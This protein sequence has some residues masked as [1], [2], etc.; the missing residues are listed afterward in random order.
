MNDVWLDILLIFFLIM[1]NGFFAGSE[2]AVVAT[3]KSRIKELIEKGIHQAKRV[4]KLQSSP[5]TFIATTQIGMT[6]V[7]SLAS[8]L[9]GVTAVEYLKPLIAT[10]PMFAGSAETISLVI[11][12]LVLSFLMLVFGE[13]VPK[14]IGLRYSDRVALII[15][16]PIVLLSKL[17]HFLIR[18]LTFTSNLI[19]KPL[20]DKTSFSESRISEEEFKLILDEGRRTGIFDKTEHE[21]ISSIFEFTDTI[22]KEVM[23]PRPDVVAVDVDTK[24]EDLIHIVTEQGYSRLPV[25]RNSL[26][27]II[28]VIYTKDLLTL[29]EHRDLIILHD[30]IRPVLFVPS[31]KKISHLLREL[32]SKKLH[33][34]IVVDEFGTIDGIITMEDILEE[35]VGEIHD[36]YDEE[37]KEIEASA[38]GSVVVDARISIDDFNKRFGIEIP[39]DAEYESISGFLL[40]ISGK[41]PEVN[42]EVR[43]G[44]ISFI[45]TKKSQR[46]IW[47]IKV[48]GIA[49]YQARKK[50]ETASPEV[51]P[52]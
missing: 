17:F 31:T 11:V 15:A 6:V 45:I 20:H 52:S 43:Y 47:Q 26:D 35:I 41:I 34:A 10:I 46:R 37:V 38:D 18:S 32:Q 29:L 8:A 14:S 42:D 50:A 24:R 40:K 21:L 49:E 30:I 51:Q 23:V 2:I 3:R 44:G 39:E 7:G 33:M 28:G 48:K 22:A 27:N 19:L 12:V 9:A 16:P 36:E 5:D 25:Y 4:E 13:L 1:L